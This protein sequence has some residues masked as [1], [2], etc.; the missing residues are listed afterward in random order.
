MLLYLVV[1]PC[2]PGT[3]V[4]MTI[5]YN[6]VASNEIV[7]LQNAIEEIGM[8]DNMRVGAYN[9][10]SSDVPPPP[11]VFNATAISYDSINT[12]W[13]PVN[14]TI[15][16]NLTVKGYTVFYRVS[17]DPNSQW[18]WVSCQNTTYLVIERLAP[19]TTYTLRVLAF[20]SM[21][22]GI[23]SYEVLE[24]TLEGTP[25]EM[26]QNLTCKADSANSVSLNWIRVKEWRGNPKCY[27]AT[28]RLFAQNETFNYTTF[29]SISQS[30]KITGLNGFT[31]YELYLSADTNAGSG[32]QAWCV[33]R[34]L[35]GVPSVGP[36][37]TD[38][39]LDEHRPREAVFI[40]NPIPNNYIN[41]RLLRYKVSYG[42]SRD[43]KNIFPPAMIDDWVDS[44]TTGYVIK[45]LSLNA[46]Y[47][48]Y[49]AGETIMGT[50]SMS[51][52]I[53]IESC[54]C[55]SMIYTAWY[56]AN[57]DKYLL[58]GNQHNVSGG[59]MYDFLNNMTKS[60]CTCNPGLKSGILPYNLYWDRTKDGKSPMRANEDELKALVD[61][62]V[63]FHL[64][65]HGK[66]SD[67]TFQSQFKYVQIANSPG[68][69]FIV[70][71]QSATL[72]KSQAVAT[73]IFSC[74]PA[75]IIIFLCSTISGIFIW[76]LDCKTNKA[77]F[78]NESF[79]RG[80]L[81]G[82]YWAF[83][84]MT[85]IGYG[86]K[87][88]RSTLAKVAA[89]IWLLTGP[90]INAIVIG[91]ISTN[92]T[93]VKFAADPI[94]YGSEIGA[95]SNS[96]EYELGVRRNAKMI[97]DFKNANDLL[98]ALF[99][100]LVHGVLLDSVI[101]TS[102]VNTFAQK[103][104]KIVKIIPV[105]CGWGVVLS[106]D[107]IK[108]EK[109]I[110]SYVGAQAQ[111]I[112]NLVNNLTKSI[113]ITSSQDSKL[114]TGLIDPN[115]EI[116]RGIYIYGSIFI[117]C[118]IVV[119]FSTEV[120]YARLKKPK[121]QPYDAKE[122]LEVKLSKFVR[123]FCNYLS[124]HIEMQIEKDEAEIKSYFRQK[125]YSLGLGWLPYLTVDEDKLKKQLKYQEIMSL[126]LSKPKYEL[127]L[128]TK[129]RDEA[130]VLRDEARVS[131]NNDYKVL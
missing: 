29:N 86:D 129:L 63:H 102:L 130:R 125:G 5:N 26:P 2:S 71:D 50:G 108:V 93:S 46:E 117:L 55:P 21:G 32:P 105:Q 80:I 18:D 24:R 100:G 91:A 131:H 23:S 94:L 128:W 114:D 61:N 36:V 37:I 12:S 22:N 121:L 13:T 103:K 74:W 34:T 31:K 79:T 47:T 6:Y 41:G 96:C 99:N 78:P 11:V 123:K 54:K 101:V 19:T 81:H 59:I 64:P 110:R 109:E 20:H 14:V 98:D 82:V 113:T 126:D 60:I 127:N 65:V 122:V 8:I 83:V 62:N 4:N 68:I 67:D 56:Q 85:T 124:V 42:I 33:F 28:Y 58:Y 111:L 88:P 7:V 106:S 97:G 30:G 45:N 1:P 73:A 72:D 84:S 119:G 115:S 49:V 92:L 112:N 52:K 70:L 17:L 10:T 76:V 107:M 39:Y 48:V 87:T 51:N 15:D 40:W 25:P 116:S 77:E 16:G 104:F 69:A 27:T 44:F 90:I 75:I 35:E 38:W 9:I 95:L 57:G 120:A 53:Y 66:A 118:A 43:G 3:W 89:I